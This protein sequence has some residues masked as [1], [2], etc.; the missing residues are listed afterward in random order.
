MGAVTKTFKS[1]NS[2]AVRLPK[3]LGIPEG[4]E[5]EIDPASGGWMLRRRSK[6][7]GRD[8][9]E[10]LEKLPKP[11]KKLKRVRIQFPNRR[12]HRAKPD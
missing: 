4:I 3:E 9:V 12:W 6:F 1:G 10:A 2:V 11:R 7:T 5:L 8:L